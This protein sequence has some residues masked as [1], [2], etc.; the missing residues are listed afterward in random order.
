MTKGRRKLFLLVLSHRER[1]GLMKL[2]DISNEGKP[3][4]FGPEYKVSG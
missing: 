4:S 3:Q 2:R 1:K